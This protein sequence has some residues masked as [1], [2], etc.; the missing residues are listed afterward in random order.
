[1]PRF[2]KVAAVTA[3]LCGLVMGN[4]APAQSAAKPAA[5][6]SAKP[7]A[8]PAAKATT[9]PARA[10][11]KKTAPAPPPPLAKAEGEQLAAAAMTHFGDYA[12]EFNQTLAVSNTP[13]NDGY[14][15]VRFNK[16]T[17]T[18]KPVLS[19]TGALRL[20]DVKG[21][22]LMLQ[23]ANKSMLMDS[24][25]GHR[26]VDACVHEKQL[27]AIAAAALRPAPDA[28]LQT[29]EMQQAAAAAAASAASAASAAA[30]VAINAAD[31]SVAAASAAVAAASAAQGAA[32][33]AASAASAATSAPAAMP[34]ASAP[35]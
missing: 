12:C 30:G 7:A 27:Q 20:E 25:I 35:R 22:M 11:A 23:I 15:D 28:L 10:P 21:Q 32:S 17:W 18:M 26:I 13:A 31:A 29:P 5:E 1:M 9:K 8:K 3:A 16:Q 4:T 14:V 33:A 24:K 2:L 34:A 19:S 6:A